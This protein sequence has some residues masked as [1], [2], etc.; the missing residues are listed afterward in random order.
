MLIVEDLLLLLTSDDGTPESV[1]TPKRYGYVAAVVTDLVLAERVTLSDDRDPRVTVISTEPTGHR[2]LDPALQ[3]L[4]EKDGAKLSSLLHDRKLTP[5]ED[6]VASLADAGIISIEERRMLG[7]V[8]EKHPV[9]DPAPERE[10]REHLRTALSGGSIT[11]HE[12]SL[13]SILAGLDVAY[14]VLDEE[15]GGLDK[16]SLKKRIEEVTSSVESSG[17]VNATVKRAVDS[18]NAAL[19]T[20]TIIPAATGGY[21]G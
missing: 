12:A 20:A 15:S 19:I 18:M 17:P 16:R 5:E 3:R 2:A 21:S 1:L 4:V 10:V 13:L 11:L 7:L 9:Q 8:P 6:T 14:K